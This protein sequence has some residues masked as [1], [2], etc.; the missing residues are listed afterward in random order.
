VKRRSFLK[1]IAGAGAAL[2]APIPAQARP[3]LEPVPTAVGMLFDSTLCIGCKACVAACKAVNGM[4][5]VIERDQLQYDSARDL[6]SR[7]LNVI[8]VYRHGNA[9]RKDA[10][11]D[12]YCFEKRS[13][14]HCVD[15][16]CV[17][18]CPVTAL[19]KHPVTG[20][21]EYDADAC[22]GCRNCMA[23]CPYNVPQYEYEDPFGAIRKCQLCNQAGVSRI[24]HGGLPAC[25]DVCP[26]GATL[27][28]RRD[29]LL[30]EAHRRLA[31]RPG[32]PFVYPRGRVDDAQ[33]VHVAPAAAYQQH[34]YGEKEAGGTQVLHIAAVSHDKLG[35]PRLPDR[36]YA[37]I[38]EGVQHTL[39]EGM[40]LPA[41]A[42]VGLM[43]VVRRNRSRDDS[44]EGHGE[45]RDES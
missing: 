34:V 14:M 3:N 42:L 39:Y 37:S 44:G 35:L 15:P 24:D 11:T 31:A 40:V 16:G 9:A 45:G 23:G 18:V 13:C 7:T 8:K 2:C 1:A 33:H 20:I 38:A 30:A 6:S 43:W 17:S 5:P 19:Y 12:G 27:F 29:Q 21:V 41:A 25:V 36:S 4:P 10:E 22:I 26:T 28:G 32:E